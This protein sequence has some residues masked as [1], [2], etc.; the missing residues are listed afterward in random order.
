MLRLEQ[1]WSER[2]ECKALAAYDRS[3]RRYA[4]RKRL[5]VIL[6]MI[7]MI[8]ISVWMVNYIHLQSKMSS[9]IE[10]DPRNEGII[11]HVHYGAY[12]RGSVLVY[13]LR[14]V[15]DTK[16]PADVFRVFLQFAD[17]LQ[18]REFDKVRLAFRG[19]TKFAL[20]GSYFRK[21]GEEY[22]WQNPVYTMRTFPENLKD[23]DGSS[24]YSGWTGGLLGVL[25]QQ[26]E[27]LNDFHRRWYMNDMVGK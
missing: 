24:A 13:D 12:I 19:H 14:A 1:V 7:A 25:G 18:S 4:M 3:P 6:V 10:T 8:V 27:D 5:L 11:V 15:P 17:N 16:S 23:A 21:L 20:E 2:P 26:M 9:V 22:S